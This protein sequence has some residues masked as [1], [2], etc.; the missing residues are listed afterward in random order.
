MHIHSFWDMIDDLPSIGLATFRERR[1]EVDILSTDLTARQAVSPEPPSIFP[2]LVTVK[3]R[4]TL[5][6]NTVREEARF[7]ADISREE[8]TRVPEYSLTDPRLAIGDGW[9]SETMCPGTLWSPHV[10]LALPSFVEFVR[11]SLCP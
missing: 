6:K 4:I 11:S 3:P 1:A 2:H 7:F 5:C 8:A 9:P 10:Y